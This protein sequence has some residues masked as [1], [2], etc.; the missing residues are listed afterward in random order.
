[1]D[2]SVLIMSRRFSSNTLPKLLCY[3]QNNYGNIIKGILLLN[4]DVGIFKKSDCLV[5]VDAS[6]K[7]TVEDILKMFN[8]SIKCLKDIKMYSVPDSII[9]CGDYYSFE[10]YHKQM[11]KEKSKRTRNKYLARKKI[12]SK[13]NLLSNEDIDNLY[14]LLDLP[15]KEHVDKMDLIE[16]YLFF[17]NNIDNYE[18]WKD[19]KKGV[20][21]TWKD[22]RN[23]LSYSKIRDIDFEKNSLSLPISLVVPRAM[24][25]RLDSKQIIRNFKGY[26][27]K[28]EET[29][30]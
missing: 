6:K 22:F 18:F 10:E 13:K 12:E 3:S 28:R 16:Y 27:K 20:A 15:E 1:M 7:K 30:R 21:S 29:C 4:Q 11:I 26:K 8:V 2:L 14:K 23:N 9:Y 19:A 24:T 17:S 5:I 25:V